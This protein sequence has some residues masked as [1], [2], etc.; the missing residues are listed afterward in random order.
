M[1]R[2]GFFGLLSKMAPA[3]GEKFYECRQSECYIQ[4]SHSTNISVRKVMRLTCF[5]AFTHSGV[6]LFAGGNSLS[7]KSGFQISVPNL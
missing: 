2:R 4:K 6:N 3:T 7:P 1:R 5:E